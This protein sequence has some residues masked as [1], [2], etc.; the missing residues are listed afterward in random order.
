VGSIRLSAYS[1]H[2]CE[3]KIKEVTVERVAAIGSGTMG[4]GVGYVTA[5]SGFETRLY[6][7][8]PEAL[9]AIEALLRTYRAEAKGRQ[10]TP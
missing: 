9:A 8:S 5:L 4:S 1:T 2:V 7:I 10:A 6:D 3:T